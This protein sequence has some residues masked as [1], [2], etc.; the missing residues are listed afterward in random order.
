M[1][2]AEN[3]VGSD[4]TSCNVGVKEVPNIDSTPMVNPEAFKYL[5]NHPQERPKH[6]ETENLRPPKVIVPLSNVKLEEGQSV[7]LACKI[8]GYP[9]P[10]VALIVK[11]LD[12]FWS[13]FNLKQIKNI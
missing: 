13:R 5:E 8:E 2:F 7:L 11:T 9:R 3:E 12:S 4:Q 1:A 10:K 6:E